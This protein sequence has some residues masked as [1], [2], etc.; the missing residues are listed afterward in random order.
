MADLSVSEGLA[1]CTSFCPSLG[2]FGDGSGGEV[3]AL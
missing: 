2:G 3:T 1:G